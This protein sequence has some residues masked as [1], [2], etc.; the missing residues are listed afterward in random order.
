MKMLLG[1][2]KLFIETL[3]RIEDKDRNII[4]FKL[5]PIQTDI[6]DSC[7]G[8]DIY[9]KPGQIG[10]S[11]IMIADYLCDVITIPGTVAIIVSYNEFIA[12]RLLAKA[13]AYY[14][15]LQELI[16]SIPKMSHKSTTEKTFPEI[17]SSFY[18]GSCGSFTFG[19]GETIHRCMLD[20]FAF[21]PKGDAERIAIPTIE[22]VPLS[23]KVSIISTP[24]GQDNEFYEMYKASKEGFEVGKSMF[25]DHFYT[26][27]QHPEYQL[28]SDSP[29][30]RS[31]DTE[32]GELS[33]DEL[34]LTDRYSATYDQLR[35]R[36]RKI[37]EMESLRRNGETGV[38]FQQEYPEDDENCFLAAGDAVYDNETI[39]QL[40]KGC[41]P[42]PFGFQAAN[43]WEQPKPGV[44]YLIGVD[45]G[46]GKTSYSVASVWRF[47]NNKQ[48][49]VATLSGKYT[50]DVMADKVYELGKYF[51]WAKIAPENNLSA[52]LACLNSKHYPNIYRQKDLVTGMQT[53]VLGWKTTPNSNIYMINEMGR[54]L[55]TIETHDSRFVSQLRNIRWC[56]RRPMAIGS[57]DYHDAACI[58]I[59]CR[60]NI[61]VSVGMAFYKK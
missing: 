42:A 27:L 6:L 35:W 13:Q 36:R 40:L 32:L 15:L 41:M 43:V 21:W 7:T 34:A 20:E 16:P 24:N 37:A 30:I 55:P 5:N 49:N 51:N 19:R 50:P 12:G 23:G 31:M 47:E 26:W 57:D 33:P 56:N 54:C 29:Y 4:P 52:F 25:K 8:R 22:R 1:D 38:M 59:A 9:L 14:D 3:L 17:H 10:A 18:V 28:T 53:Q 48:I 2:R 46:E 11:S 45:P 61:E 44:D 39:N 58:A 60:P